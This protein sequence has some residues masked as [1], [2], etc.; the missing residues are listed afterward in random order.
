MQLTQIDD[1][2]IL[3]VLANQQCD[4]SSI[5]ASKQKHHVL[6]CPTYERC[7]T[8][9]EYDVLS[10]MYSCVYPYVK[11]TWISQFLQGNKATIIVNGEEFLSL[12]SQSDR[13]ALNSSMMASTQRDQYHRTGAY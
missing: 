6:T 5:I 11:F 9:A 12:R 10:K 13:S 8:D 3:Q 2:V 7:L 4:V 1:Q